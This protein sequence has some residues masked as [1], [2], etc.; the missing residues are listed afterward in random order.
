MS[1]NDAASAGS[2]EKD[3]VA[4]ERSWL[5]E[6]LPQS[7]LE[8]AWG[9]NP[10]GQPWYAAKWATFIL[11]IPFVFAAV[12]GIAGQ[13]V[14]E[15]AWPIGLAVTVL[16]SYPLWIAVDVLVNLLVV[17]LGRVLIMMLV[18]IV[19][20]GFPFALVGLLAKHGAW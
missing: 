10:Y 14:P 9:L 13:Y 6:I 8:P 2:T 19:A 7:D 18:I 17:I 5:D 3:S 12:A 15:Q 11:L 4:S 20:F 1:K 16:A